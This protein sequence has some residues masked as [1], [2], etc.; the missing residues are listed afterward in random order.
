[1]NNDAQRCKTVQLR[2]FLIPSFTNKKFSCW[3]RGSVQGDLV[4][5]DLHGTRLVKVQA[6]GQVD[7]IQ[8]DFSQRGADFNR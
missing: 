3:V 7:M 5:D 6:P 2:T 8:M 1:M 4:G